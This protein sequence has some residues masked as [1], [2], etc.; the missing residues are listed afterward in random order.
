MLDRIVTGSAVL[1]VWHKIEFSCALERTP[2]SNPL[3]SNQTMNSKIELKSLALGALLGIAAMLGIAAKDGDTSHPV[4]EYGITF[5]NKA[6]M[7]PTGLLN[8]LNSDGRDGWEA[9]AI[10]GEASQPWVLMRRAAKPK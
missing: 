4:W 5:N 2:A 8:R 6:V 3:P 10:G 7:F 1:F 9:V